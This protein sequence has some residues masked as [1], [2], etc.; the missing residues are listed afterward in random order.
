[1]QKNPFIN[2]GAA[3]EVVPV[4]VLSSSKLRDCFTNLM[5]SVAP[6]DAPKKSKYGSDLNDILLSDKSQKE[7]VDKWLLQVSKLLHVTMQVATVMTQG[8]SVMLCLEDHN[9]MTALVCILIDFF[10]AVV[11]VGCSQTSIHCIYSIR[12]TV[13]RL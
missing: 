13:E 1:M 3:A 9:D 10:P 11:A 5:S 2:I 6:P 4:E 12:T 8:K 7:H